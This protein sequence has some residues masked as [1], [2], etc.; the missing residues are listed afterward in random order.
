MSI[1]LDYN[2]STPVDERVIKEMINVYQ[3]YY[4]N[5]DSRTHNFGTNAKALVEKSRSQIASLLQIDKSEIVFTSGATESDNLAILGLA[6]YGHESNKKHIITTA[7]EHKAVLEPAKHLANC[8]FDVEFIKPGVSGRIDETELLSR[9]RPDTLLVS[10]MHAN[11]ETGIIQPIMKIGEALNKTET[12]FHIDA[13][14]SFGKLVS[15]LRRVKYDLLSITAHKIYGP[16]GV[17]ALVLK[18]R[19]YKR[20]PV[21]PLMYGG[22]HEC[23]LR[24][25][26]LPVALITGFG[27]AAEIADR[28]NVKNLEIYKSIKKDIINQLDTAGIDYDING[29]Q[30][31]CM[32]NTLNISFSGIDSEALMLSIKD[33][34]GV[35]NGSA[36][37]S[38]DY[39]PSHVLIAMNLT[40]ERIESTI[41][42]SW[43]TNIQDIAKFSLIINSVKGLRE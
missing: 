34:C 30:Q 9:V 40:E 5:A 15:E 35:S 42:I 22:S 33:N 10:V 38:N 41:R 21:K 1:Y 32:P 36:C 4:G 3:N 6:S 2:A 43:G 11:N 14:Q 8:G 12:F 23:G 19:N 16:Q 24:P 27:F 7:I 25:G 13:A 26:T 18:R 29:D 37:T 20:P 39:S 31:Y 28:E 17:G